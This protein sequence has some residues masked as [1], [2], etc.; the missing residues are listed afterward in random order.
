MYER[1][2]PGAHGRNDRFERLLFVFG[3]GPCQHD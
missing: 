3:Y 2:S 1:V